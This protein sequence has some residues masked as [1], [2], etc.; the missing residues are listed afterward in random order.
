[1]EKSWKRAN[2]QSFD[3]GIILN[4]RQH[5]RHVQKQ[6]N[7]RFAKQPAQMAEELSHKALNQQENRLTG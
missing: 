6:D 5:V 4:K 1:M 2:S 3:H 7:R